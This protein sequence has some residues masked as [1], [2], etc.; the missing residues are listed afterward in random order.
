MG[1]SGGADVSGAMTGILRPGRRGRGS[2]GGRGGSPGQAT[3]QPGWGRRSNPAPPDS[4]RAKNAG[5]YLI[6]QGPRICEL[7][8]SWIVPPG[9][10]QCV[11]RP[12]TRP[13]HRPVRWKTERN[14]PVQPTGPTPPLR[15]TDPPRFVR[16]PR[17]STPAASVTIA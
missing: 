15:V 6:V 9:P 3:P 4:G 1:V 11:L 17:L 13:V 5:N 10:L 16:V 8:G 2:H 7:P 12:T 14:G